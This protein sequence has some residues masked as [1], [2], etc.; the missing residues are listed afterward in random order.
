MYKTLTKENKN[1]SDPLVDHARNRIKILKSITEVEGHNLVSPGVG[2]LKSSRHVLD[3]EKK[4]K[5]QSLAVTSMSMYN[6][7]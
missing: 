3:K 6:S 1:Q 2:S 7:Y 5:R 4:L